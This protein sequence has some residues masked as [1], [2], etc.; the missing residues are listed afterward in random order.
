MSQVLE[1]LARSGYFS[2]LD[3]HCAKAL[4]KLVDGVTEP[5]LLAL[6]LASRQTR[7]GHVC[8]DLTEFAGTPIFDPEGQSLADARWASLDLWAKAF[9]WPTSEVWHSAL[10]SSPLV[11]DAAARTPFVL[12]GTRLYLRRYFEHEQRL[13]EMLQARVASRGTTNHGVLERAQVDRLFGPIGAELDRQ[14]LA[15]VLASLQPLLV[16]TGGP[17]TGKTATVVK[18]LALWAEQARRQNNAQFAVKL[19]APTGKAAARLVGSVQRA[20]AALPVDADIQALIPEDASTIHRALGSIGGSSTDFRYNRENPLPVDAVVVDEASMVDVA[21]MRRLVEAVPLNARLVL[22]GDRHQLASVEAGAVLGDISAGAGS[23]N[24]SAGLRDILLPFVG[25]LPKGVGSASP[26]SD[27]VVELTRSYRFQGQ[28]GIGNLASAIREGN[29]GGALEVLEAEEFSDVSWVDLSDPA[30]LAKALAKPVRDGYRPFCKATEPLAALS[31]L[32][33]FRVLCAHRRG[34][35]GVLTLG[36]IIEDILRH[37]GMIQRSGRWYAHQPILITRNDYQVG[38]FNGDIGVVLPTAARGTPRA[39]FLAQDS[40]VRDLAPSRL[41]AHETVFAMSI[42]KSQGSEFD[43]VVLVLP[44][45]TSPL[46]T[47]ELLYTGVTR[48]KK[49]VTIVGAGAS[50][51][52]A[53]ERPVRR[54]SGLREALWPG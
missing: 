10:N 1:Q 32:E 51:R 12:Q 29:V 30:R 50:L 11:G 43:H 9:R 45:A 5:V 34:P 42:H 47:R 21:L 15:A 7:E 23:L 17:G 25:E 37:A 33:E 24:Y 48:A 8:L 20:K 36:P 38:L 13:A 54:V 39:H 3:L 27:S 16:I 19:L 4:A 14:R 40:K 2:S 18:V 41:P 53:V 31:A 6:A 52:A 28:S 46:L 22:M 44:E 49:R 26:M 35:Y